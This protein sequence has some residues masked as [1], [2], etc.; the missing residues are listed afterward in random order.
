MLHVPFHCARD[1]N[2]FDV[3][4]FRGDLP[5]DLRTIQIGKAHVYD[6]GIESNIS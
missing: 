4:E 2:R 5:K 1:S 6:H 3:R